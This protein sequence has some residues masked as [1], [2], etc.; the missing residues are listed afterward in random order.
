MS[1]S[2]DLSYGLRQLRNQ[3]GFTAV[4]LATLALGIGATTA[5]FSLVNAMLLRPLPFADPP[6]L[7]ALHEGV[8]RLGYPKMGFSPPDLAIF[9]RA[10]TSFSA[11][12]W[13]KNEHVNVS[14]HDQPERVIAARVSSSLFPMLGARPALGRTFTEEE[15]APG[16]NV[17]LLSY[18]FWQR[19]YGGALNVVGQTLEIERNPYSV[20]GVMQP[21]F[22]FP[23]RGPEDN[24]SPAEVWLPMAF[25]PAEL[26]D[27][28]GAYF[29]S[30]VA[31]LRPGVTLGQARGEAESLAP[32]IV[33][34]YPPAIAKVF[35][36]EKGLE[37]DAS[38]YQE[39]IVASVRTLLFVLMA[40]VV[41]VLLIA[42]ANI[43]NLLMSRA[44]TRRKEIAIRTALGA[45]RLRLV[46]QM[47]TESLLLASCGGMFGFLLAFLIRDLI[48]ALVPLSI[49]LPPRPSI[50]GNV[51]VFAAAASFAS[52]ILFGL[53][54]A[55]EQS[56]A[57][58]E[59]RLQEGRRSATSGRGQYR[60]QSW[61]V[62]LEF[63]SAVVLLTGAG[64]LL[65]SFGKLL[66]T[67]P[68]FRP[69]KVLTLNVPLPRSAYPAAGQ[70][71][72]SYKEL[73]SRISDVPGVE[74]AGLS[75]DLPLGGREMVSI[76]VEG[77]ANA[78]TG[79]PQ[80]ICQ[81]WILR[82]YFPSLGI[83]LLQGRWFTPQD[84]IDSEPVAIVSLGT[85]RKFWPGQNAIGR[86]IRWGVYAP[87]QTVVGVV[88]DVN[89]GPIQTPISP[90]VYRPYNQLS[91]PFLEEDPFGDWHTMNFAVRTQVEPASLTA[92]VINAV[93]SL[94]PDLAVTNVRVMTEVV[95]RSFAA[96]KFNTVLVG[97]LAGLALLLAGI[98]IYGVLAYVVAQQT[99]EIGLRMALG[100]RPWEVLRS[101][102]SRGARLALTGSGLGLA[103]T[104][105]LTRLFE[106]LLYGISAIDPITFLSVVALLA[107]VGLVASFVPAYR[108]AKIEPMVALR[109]E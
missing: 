97:A 102:L 23:L 70:V 66:R 83:P 93:H 85:A 108:A 12:G 94:D 86:H 100:A 105:G 20:I 79:T 78:A 15:D 19:R 2:Q 33:S 7:V 81:S 27:W 13:F 89:Q 96:P 101:I 18:G 76:N 64:L 43:A 95:H 31:R 57:S 47:L 103:A 28:G 38:P 67:N 30:V 26:E 17:V 73:L 49:P 32:V 21:R 91:G 65:R 88:A 8:R 37:V 77:T 3:P 74:A 29:T 51:L 72:N 63:A 61:F 42:C 104:L 16:H 69:D 10:Q 14:G 9:A 90:H 22:E 40:A 87:W 53:V 36:N 98:G 5:I 80:A 62:I 11:I 92:A 60:L 39:D 107:V 46:R 25:T 50:D 54:P 56:F 41:F 34:H 52:A 44:A 45:T 71:E 84:R 24:G 59:K 68:G 1:L 75:N 106:S 48:L 99:G 4:G 6:R 109:Y 82:D 55:L 58:T 35:Q